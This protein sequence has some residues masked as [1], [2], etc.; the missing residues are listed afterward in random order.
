MT[1]RLAI[2][3]DSLGAMASGLCL[4]HCIATPLLFIAQ[5]C[6]ASCSEAAPIWWQWI[7]Y[8]F[9]SISFFAVYH[10]ARTTSSEIMK[11]ALWV[12]WSF[13]FVVILNEKLQWLPLPGATIYVAALILVAL[14]LYNLKFCQCKTDNC[15]TNHE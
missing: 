4:L 14:H 5:T 3:S 11:V 6:S 9:L 15:C 1:N 10:S 7:D 12:S 8:I 13:L 2:R